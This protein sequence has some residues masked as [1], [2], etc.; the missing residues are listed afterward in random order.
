MDTKYF[1]GDCIKKKKVVLLQE[2][3][4]IATYPHVPLK[5]PQKSVTPSL[6]LAFITCSQTG[7]AQSMGQQVVSVKKDRQMHQN[8]A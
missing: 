5:A 7:A 3:V 4:V 2:I 6:V 8:R 1:L